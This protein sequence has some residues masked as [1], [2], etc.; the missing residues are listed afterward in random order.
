MNNKLFTKRLFILLAAKSFLFFVLVIRLFY[1]Q[2]KENFYF[3]SLSEKNRTNLIPIIPKRGIIYDGYGVVLADNM[4]LWEILF[5]KSNIN[6]SIQLFLNTISSIVEIS[7][8]EK[9]RILKEYKNKPAYYPILIKQNLSQS[10]IAGVETFSYKLPGIFIRPFYRRFY[11]YKDDFAH[12]LG[13][14]SIT[15]DLS[16]SNGIAGWFVGRS[17]I[18]LTMNNFLR[19]EVGYSKYEINARGQAIRKLDQIPS[20]QGHAISLTIDQVLQSKVNQILS[21]YHSG[22]V[23]V[24]DITNGNILAM[25]SYPSFDP[26]LFSYGIPENI[27]KDLTNNEKGPLYNKIISGLYPPGSTIKPL[28]VLKALQDKLVTPDTIIE[29]KGYIDVGK[30][31]FHCWKRHGHGKV[32]IEQALYES[33]DIWFYELARK[34]DLHNMSDAAFEFGFGQKHLNLLQGEQKGRLINERISKKPTLGDNIVGII[35]QGNWLINPM[36]LSIMTALCANNGST[37]NLNLIKSIEYDNKII[38]PKNNQ[39]DIKINYNKEYL[40]LVKKTFF[41]TINHPKGT[42]KIAAT[43]DPNWP[44]CGKT[45]TAQVRRITREERDTTGVIANYNLPWIKRDHA[46][47]TG[48]VPYEKPLYAITVIIDH[49]G[50]GGSIAAPIAKEVALILRDRHPIYEA[51]KERLNKILQ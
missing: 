22:S 21:N 35:G 44:L 14:T 32:N 33:C 17:G 51:E 46:L 47:F 13:Y 30:D 50:G 43:Y 29:C 31:R 40:S 42:A 3:N 48:F 10:E 19:G 5:I 16:K 18:E 23:F 45:G 8:K 11:P 15:D 1:L 26:N 39:D 6:Q 36:Q 28:M 27:W 2:I 20:K 24:H 4:F 37:P 7:D 25:P 41:D 12:L 49:G 34:L 9:E 38:Y